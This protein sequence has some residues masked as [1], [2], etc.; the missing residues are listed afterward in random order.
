MG[1]KRKKIFS[2]MLQPGILLAAIAVFSASCEKPA[3]PPPP[4]R[5]FYFVIDTSGSM[6]GPEKI[7]D[8]VKSAFPGLLASVQTG[9]TVNLTSFDDGTQ[10]LGEY[11]I[12]SEEDRQ[13]VIS[14]IQELK[15][16]GLHTDMTAM[17]RFLH[18]T[19]KDGA[20]QN[21]VVVILSDGL[22]DP[23]PDKKKNGVSLE[24]IRD[25]ARPSSEKFIYYVNL[26]RFSDPVLEE[27]LGIKAEHVKVV[28]ARQVQESGSAESG[29]AAP[30]QDKE[31]EP[32]SEPVL[33]EDLG[34]GEVAEE[35][36][37]DRSGIS[38]NQIPF[39]IIAGVLIAIALMLLISLFLIW[40]AKKAANSFQGKL[41]FY[42][43]D[44]KPYMGK[45]YNLSKVKG[46]NLS[47]GSKGSVN[48][49]IKDLG[50]DGI[51]RLKTKVTDGR[52][53]LQPAWGSAAKFRTA[54][55]KS[56]VS[57]I[58]TGGKFRLGNYIFEYGDAK[59]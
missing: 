52:H 25:P 49:K 15:P 40:L 58:P 38:E 7:I 57:K 28:E 54:D 21:S 39:Y 53:Y 27:K 31:K 14:R 36:R 55:N 9:D 23:H 59:E 41:L 20:N 50:T 34:L 30:G 33:K 5:T 1:L 2:I 13:K 19:L 18:E 44:S 24:D 42:E 48:L 45:S 43:A 26:G 56:A 3:P 11:R 6:S 46:G 32:V 22:N 17:I 16:E 51:A 8:K 29:N 47:I 37:K 12:S 4:A 10:N 35:I